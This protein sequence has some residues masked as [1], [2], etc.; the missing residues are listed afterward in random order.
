MRKIKVLLNFI[1]FSVPE[2]IG[3][4][5]NVI[6][7]MTGN[8]SFPSPD[9][10]LTDATTLVNGLETA[11]VAAQDGGHTAVSAMHDKEELSD[12]TFRKLADY[13]DRIADGD[14]TKILSS[15]FD[16]TKQPA[17]VTKSELTVDDGAN[18]GSVKL[19][20]KAVEG[21]KTYIWQ[22][23]KDSLPTDET[24]WAVAG[25]STKVSYEISELA[26]A[27]KYWFRVAAIT[28][29]GTTDF[30]NPVMKVVE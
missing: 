2:K 26:V 18:S 10:S 1:R 9:V 14:E 3:F 8:I 4:Y 16:I 28:A 5:R 27:C 11:H 20:A 19:V 21:A 22:Y 7:R 29:K 6:S 30:C 24:G 25:Y 23:A 13:V 17:P 12:E 15:G